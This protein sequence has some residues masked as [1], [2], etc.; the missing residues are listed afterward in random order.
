MLVCIVIKILALEEYE[1]RFDILDIEDS[2][3]RT[4]HAEK[5]KTLMGKLKIMTSQRHLVRLN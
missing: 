5:R 1:I 2:L 4:I 3:K